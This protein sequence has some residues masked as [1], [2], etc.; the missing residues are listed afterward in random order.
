MKRRAI[1]TSILT[2]L[3]FSYVPHT[4][5]APPIPDPLKPWVEWV[6]PATPEESCVSVGEHLQCKDRKIDRFFVSS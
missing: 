2:L 6:A 4:Q 5:A 1:F 3:T